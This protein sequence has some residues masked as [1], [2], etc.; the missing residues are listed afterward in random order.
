[1]LWDLFKSRV[2]E[3][4]LS[5]SSALLVHSSL[6]A[7]QM[8]N[9]FST[10]QDPVSQTLG[11]AQ[12]AVG[13]IDGVYKIVQPP[14][15]AATNKI[16]ETTSLKKFIGAWWKEAFEYGTCMV[17]VD[18]ETFETHLRMSNGLLNPRGDCTANSPWGYLLQA[19]AINPGNGVLTW[20][21]ASGRR[22]DMP[23]GKLAMDVRG[24]AF[25]HLV[26]LYKV[27]DRRG[28]TKPGFEVKG[29]RQERGRCRLS[30]GWLDWTS[31]DEDHIIAQFEPDTIPKLNACKK[32]F[33]G[34]GKL[35]L[36]ASE[37]NLWS[38]YDKALKQGVSDD[39]LLWPDPNKATLSERL[40][41]LITS[42]TKLLDYRRKPCL[43]THGWL[44]HATRIKMR[45]MSNGGKDDTFLVDAYK[46]LAQHPRRALMPEAKYKLAQEQVRECFF[47]E[48]DHFSMQPA[49]DVSDVSNRSGGSGS[50]GTFRGITVDIILRD[51]LELYSAEKPASWK[52]QLYASKETVLHVALMDQ[53]RKYSPD[54]VRLLDFT[55]KD[56]LWNARVHL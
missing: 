15:L 5:P 43:I 31:S 9:C 21:P 25:C 33:G 22:W 48:D 18:I 24:T 6:V 3:E 56:P 1:V 35:F 39:E 54:N 55:P 20:K 52:G 27:E 2:V 23:E 7:H 36:A 46:V 37:P 29:D 53:N 13:L 47:F 11:D 14:V 32:P 17:P 49:Q 34:L 16:D 8:G 42:L 45:A 51:T 30:F 28:E 19:L 10:P 12:Q 26:N 50:F 44:D 38:F 4:H 41:H 40:Q